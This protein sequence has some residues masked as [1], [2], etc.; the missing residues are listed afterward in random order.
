M[1]EPVVLGLDFGGTKIALAVCDAGGARL[2]SVTI[3]TRPAEGARAVFT[4]TVAAA[5]ELLAGRLPAAVGA[6]TFGIPGDGGVD[7]APAV[8]GWEHL[9][10]AREL[11]AAFEGAAVRVVTDVKAAA[12]IE[13]GSG[14]LAG[15]DP[16]LYLNLGTG[17]AVAIVAGGVVLNGRNGASG[18]I[19]YNLRALADVGVPPNGRVPLEDTVSGRA[20]AEGAAAL[21]PAAPH[22]G[23]ALDS[24]DPAV[25]R[26]LGAFVGELAFHLVN[27]AIA[28]DPA[29][30]A[31]GGGMVRSWRHLHDGLRRA[32][33]AAVPY[34]PE[35]VPA[36]YPFDGPL[37]G[38]LALAL[39]AV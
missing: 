25:G 12:G 32:L 3:P 15:C 38:A 11:G 19:G 21:R 20:L 33:D 35:L 14:A 5:R 9:A 24:G 8:P 6:A 31:V 17:L 36:R 2:G 28:V 27:L 13:A 1:S 39:A 26:L 7:L 23:A 29:R 18:E 34:P 30:I 22:L 10:L 16:G 37:R 4:R